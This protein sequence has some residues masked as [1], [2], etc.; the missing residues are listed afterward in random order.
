MAY[1]LKGLDPGE[2]I[3]QLKSI[4]FFFSSSPARRFTSRVRSPT[5]RTWCWLDASGLWSRRVRSERWWVNTPGETW[6]ESWRPWWKTR[7]APPSWLSGT[8]RWPRSRQD[9]STS[10]QVW[11]PTQFYEACLLLSRTCTSGVVIRNLPWP[12]IDPI[13]LSIQL[14]ESSKLK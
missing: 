9:S 11:S 3:F 2:Y 12:W 14:K 4:C 8:P 5:R 13:Y 10:S 7:G 6:P 1:S